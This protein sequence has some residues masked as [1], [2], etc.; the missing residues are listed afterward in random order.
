MTGQ[1]AC[2]W[3]LAILRQPLADESAGYRRIFGYN[4]PVFNIFFSKP[5]DPAV[6]RLSARFLLTTP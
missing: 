3:S 1:E 2:P 4:Y 6:L 5:P